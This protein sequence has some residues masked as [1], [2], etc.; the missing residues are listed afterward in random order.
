[1]EV[2]NVNDFQLC[3]HRTLSK[4]RNVSYNS[5]DK[6]SYKILLLACSALLSVP[7]LQSIIVIIHLRTVVE[8]K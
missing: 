5:D 1:M 2:A 7:G 3:S 6:G 4:E 8:I